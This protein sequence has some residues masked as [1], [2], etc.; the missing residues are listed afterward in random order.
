MRKGGA[1]H[2]GRPNIEEL[3]ERYGRRVY[4]LAYR[5]IGNRQDAEDVAQETFLQVYRGMDK[6]R[7]ESDVYT[8]IYRIAVNNCLQIKRRLSRVYIDS[9]DEKIDQFK[10]DIPAEVEDWE[11]DPEKK[12]L[13]DELLCWIRQECHHFMA[14]RLTD[15]QRVVYILRM[16]LHFSLDDISA[17]VQVDKTTVKARLQRAKNNLRSYFRSRCQ[18]IPGGENTCS[19]H[20]RIGFALAYAP[21]IL[22]R[23]RNDDQSGVTR[24]LIRSTLQNIRSVD[25]VYGNLPLEN[26]QTELLLRYLKD[27]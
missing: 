18:W 24:E 10:H 26:Y 9:L 19:C 5:L 14:F 1:V 11:R 8:W 6:F 21:D 27:S 25:D 2:M 23:L 17:I 4:N 3:V 20:S 13:Y 7:G 12:Y 15:E 22:K 16:V